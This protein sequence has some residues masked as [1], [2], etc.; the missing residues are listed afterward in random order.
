MKKIIYLFFALSA[1]VSCKHDTT[2]SKQ[3]T[4]STTGGDKEVVSEP[5]SGKT[6]GIKSGILVSEM[7]MMGMGKATVENNFD[8]YG[9]VTLTNTKAAIMS[10][11]TVT[12]NLKKDGW[13]Y[14]WTDGQKDGKKFK[15][16]ASQFSKDNLDIDKLSQEMKDKLK[17]KEEGTADVLGKS[18]KVFSM[19]IAEKGMSMAGKIYVWEKLPMKSE[20]GAKGMN[21]V[22]Q[23]KSLDEHPNFAPGFFDVP[24]SV[25]FTEMQA[26]DHPEMN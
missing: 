15:M 19:T 20:F 9:N 14:V 5:V 16:D 3:E 7:D 18:C 26:T 24:T 8:D 2:D 10:M 6:Y 1:F 22:M 21:I 17:L 23:P 4:G 11:N 12:H 13:M 25:T